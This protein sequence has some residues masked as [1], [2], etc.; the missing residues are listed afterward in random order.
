VYA[1]LGLQ[2]VS[3][4]RLRLDTTAPDAAICAQ[5]MAVPEG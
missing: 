4:N 1:E 3:A 5:I 2:P